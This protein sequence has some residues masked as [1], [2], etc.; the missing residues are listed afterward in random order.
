VKYF[1]TSP[2]SPE[3]TA[4]VLN[5]LVLSQAYVENRPLPPS[6][7]RIPNPRKAART[8]SLQVSRQESFRS[9]GPA[10]SGPSIFPRL[11]RMSNFDQA[12]EQDWTDAQIAPSY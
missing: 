4:L 7:T 9:I 6:G 3:T 10:L 11:F 2:Y 8:G 12:C 5:M 1:F